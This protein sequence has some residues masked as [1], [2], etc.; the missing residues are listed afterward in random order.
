MQLS[1]TQVSFNT[2]PEPFLMDMTHQLSFKVIH[3]QYMR[4]L[5]FYI[6][7]TEVAAMMGNAIT[8]LDPLR[9][10]MR[11]HLATKMFFQKRA[12]FLV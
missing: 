4:Y 1:G 10:Q 8:S 12:T 3:R 6:L 5:L 7:L 9:T 2:S 11:P